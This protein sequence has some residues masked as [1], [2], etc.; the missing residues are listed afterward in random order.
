MLYTFENT[1]HFFIDAGKLQDEFEL[2]NLHVSHDINDTPNGV[3]T[4][5]SVII[6]VFTG[7]LTNEQLAQAT[8]I[9]STH[10]EDIYPK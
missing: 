4:S 1:H 8:E 3:T 5:R 6:V 7:E 10:K 2:A 9:I